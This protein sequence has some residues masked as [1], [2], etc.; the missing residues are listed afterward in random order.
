MSATI[1]TYFTVNNFGDLSMGEYFLW[2]GDVYQKTEHNQTVRSRDGRAE[3]F[4]DEEQV[5]PVD[6]T[7]QVTKRSN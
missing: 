6:V 1:Q 5:E 3:A 4:F 7:L 2:G